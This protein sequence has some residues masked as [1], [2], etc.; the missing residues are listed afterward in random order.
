VPDAYASQTTAD[1]DN[2]N[3]GNLTGS[4]SGS[5]DIVSLG[6]TMIF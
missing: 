4:I 2:A 1:P 6:V 3:R 5:A